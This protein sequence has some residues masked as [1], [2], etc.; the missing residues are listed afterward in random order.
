MGKE[1]ADDACFSRFGYTDDGNGRD[2]DASGNG[3]ERSDEARKGKIQLG[4]S[5]FY[6]LFLSHCR[7]RLCTMM[8]L[9]LGLGVSAS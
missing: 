5:L 9:L 4:R 6:T 8:F 2:G 3:N 7:L 1:A